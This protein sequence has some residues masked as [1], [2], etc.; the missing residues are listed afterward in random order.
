M[1]TTFI[2][3]YPNITQWIERQGWIE[4]GHDEYSYSLLRCLDEGGLIW[5]SRPEHT[6]IDEALQA[7]ED[8]LD[9]LLKE[10]V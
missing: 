1:R 6:Q 9:D 8:A 10:C 3:A 7:L 4:L 5:E 2:Q